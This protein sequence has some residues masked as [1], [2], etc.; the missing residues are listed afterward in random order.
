MEQG[1][2]SLLTDN[3]FREKVALRAYEI[4]EDRGGQIGRDIDDWLQAETDVLS[5]IAQ[6]QKMSSERIQPSGTTSTASPR[7]ARKE[8]RPTGTG[9]TG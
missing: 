4:Y 2:R 7:R 3:E 5:E 6:Q 8:Q 1:K 9:T